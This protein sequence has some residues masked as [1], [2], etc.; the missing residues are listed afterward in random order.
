MNATEAIRKIA[1]LAQSVTTDSSAQFAIGAIGT[2]A[3]LAIIE[4]DYQQQPESYLWEGSEY[5]E[6]FERPDADGCCYNCGSSQHASSECPEL[7]VPDFS[8]EL[9]FHARR[10]R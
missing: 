8:D 9:E 10:D 2:L 1:L 7:F 3:R 5:V 4:L 6:V